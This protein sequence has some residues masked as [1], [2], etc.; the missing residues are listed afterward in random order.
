VPKPLQRRTAHEFGA[1]EGCRL[2][3]VVGWN[4]DLT[5]SWTSGSLEL[6]PT[7]A[8]AETIDSELIINRSPT[9]AVFPGL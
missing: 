9:L 6:Q 4:C 3:K 2:E 5:A 8:A 7:H 1:R